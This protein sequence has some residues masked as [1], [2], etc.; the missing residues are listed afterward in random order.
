[1]PPVHSGNGPIMRKCREH[2]KSKR[3]FPFHIL[4][5]SL[6]S[7]LTD[8]IL[9]GLK[10]F[11]PSALQ[12]RR[13]GGAIWQQCYYECISFVRGLRVQLRTGLDP[14][15]SRQFWWNGYLIVFGDC[16]CHHAIVAGESGRGK[17]RGNPDRTIEP[18]AFTIR[19]RSANPTER[20]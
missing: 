1:M 4:A 5:N 7:E 14:Q 2:E 6:L 9:A 3:I 17:Q 10:I 13:D 16:R 20:T 11:S 12:A 8:W 19:K 15:V 18:S